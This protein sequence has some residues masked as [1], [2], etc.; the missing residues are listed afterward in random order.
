MLDVVLVGC[1]FMGRMHASIWTRTEGARLVGVVDKDSGRVEAFAAEFGVS[2][3]PDLDT[4]LTATEAQAVDLCVPTDLHAA[5]TIEAASLGRHVLVEKPMA[6]DLE[7][8][9][10]MIATAKEAGARLMVAHCIRFWPEYVLL[11]EA[12]DDGRFGRLL[13]LDL[14]RHGAFPTWAAENWLAD[15]RRAGGAAL[16][17]HCHDTDFAAYL[18]GEPD[19]IS[20][21]G[22]VDGRG[23]SGIATTMTFGETL[24]TLSGGWNLPQGAPFRMAYRAVFERGAMILDGALTIYEEGKEPFT[25]ASEEDEIE[26]GGNLTSLGAYGAEIAEFVRCVAAGEDS[27]RCLPESSRASLALVLEEIARVHG[28][29]DHSAEYAVARTD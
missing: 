19:T 16:D 10:T 4:A 6:R 26:G 12:V 21:W 8:A 1:G 18:L 23:V 29:D 17:M 7:G 11:K 25:P 22:T 5:L 14:A 2:G 27:P 13:S 9:D 20:S 24:V 15:E 3:F 28:G